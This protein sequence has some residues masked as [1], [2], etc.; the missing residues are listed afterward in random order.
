NDDI[1]LAKGWEMRLI[2][3]EAL[4]SAGKRTE[5][6]AMINHVRSAFDVPDAT[7]ATDDEAWT[8][9]KRERLITLWLE[10]RRLADLHRFN[11]AFLSGRDYCF[12]FSRGE[13]NSN[14]NLAGCTGDACS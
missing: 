1:P 6:M 10:G 8:A 2:E 12:P 3:A 13:I 11:D 5:A 14:P 4:L 9:L 7:A